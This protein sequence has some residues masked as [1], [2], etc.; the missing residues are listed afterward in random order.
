[1]PADMQKIIQTKESI[2]SNIRFKGPSLP[3]Q[4]ARSANLNTIFASAFLSELFAE[5]RIKM[6]NLKVGSSSLYYLEGQEKQLE[7]FIEYLNHKE[8]EAF[9]K[10]KE[11]KVLEEEKLD[12]AIR[13]AIKEIRDFAIPLKIKSDQ[14]NKI[15]WK[16]AF[17]TDQEALSIIEESLNPSKIERKTSTKSEDKEEESKSSSE[18]IVLKEKDIIKDEIQEKESKE[19]KSIKKKKQVEESKFTKSVKEYLSSKDI[20]IISILEES[21]KE[22]SAKI[23]TDNLFGKQEY[24]LAAKDKKRI[25]PEDLIIA[26]HKSQIEKM[27]LLYLSTGDLD[28]KHIDYLKEWRNLI[29][30]EKLKLN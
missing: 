20:E 29:K 16:Y 4:I 10:I 19:I 12:P 22:L 24:Y 14:Q 21:K 30:F 3:I 27:P 25:I 7:N 18:K 2:I 13:V 5:N 28:K 26:L 1:M 9:Q 11:S 6:S 8:K 23:R 15:F 17:I